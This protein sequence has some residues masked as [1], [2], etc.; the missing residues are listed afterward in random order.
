MR[1]ERFHMR[2]FISFPLL[3]SPLSTPKFPR[4][5]RLRQWRRQT[6]LPPCAQCVRCAPW[7]WYYGYSYTQGGMVWSAAALIIIAVMYNICMGNAANDRRKWCWRGD[8]NCFELNYYEYWMQ[9]HERVIHAVRSK[10]VLY[11]T[12]AHRT[13]RILSFL[14]LFL[15]KTKNE[16]NQQT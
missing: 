2:F 15:N 10:Q 11:G 9:Q 1:T 12:W 13:R 5:T 3:R 4:I 6:I 8:K 16:K 14:F 7:K